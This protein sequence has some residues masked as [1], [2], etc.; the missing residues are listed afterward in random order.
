M[1]TLLR[2]EPFRGAQVASGVVVLVTLA[3]L[4]ELRMDWSAGGHLLV[5]GTAAVFVWGLVLATPP[6]AGQP[7][8]WLSALCLGALALLVLSLGRIAEVL[9]AE[10]F[11]TGAGT[12]TWAAA[13]VCVASAALARRR[14]SPACSLVAGLAG[15][16]APVLAASWAFDASA[17]AIRWILLLCAVAL[18]LSAVATRDRQPDHAAQLANAGGLA[19][20]AIGVSGGLLVFVFGVQDIGWGWELVLLT[21]GFGLLAYGTVD[22]QRGPVLV[23][24]LDLVVFLAG[25]GLAGGGLEGGSDGL[26][27]V[28]SLIGWPIALALMALLLLTVGLRPT[29]PAPPEPGAGHDEPPVVIDVRPER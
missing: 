19:V 15:T 24:L 29:R 10:G 12:A 5:S 22:S 1:P 2:V 4:L 11:Y 6:I 16:A 14:R 21:A 25:A 3:A 9:G 23:G 8:T 20:V 13:L 18:A 7:T 17:A 27:G 28:D 26:R